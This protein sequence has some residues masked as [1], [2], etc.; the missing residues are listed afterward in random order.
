MSAALVDVREG[1]MTITLNRPETL[2]ALDSA[3]H[4][5]LGTALAEAADPGVRVVV[6]TGAGRGFCSGQDVSELGD[7]STDRLRL[8]SNPN[9]LALRTLEKPVIAAVNGVAA[10]AG[11]ALACAC[12]VRIASERARFV[13]G[14]VALG[15]VP[16]AG[17]TW[18]VTRLLGAAQTFE[19]LGSNRPLEAVEAKQMG[20]VGEV[21]PEAAFSARVAVVAAAYAAAPTRALGLMKLLIDGAAGRTLDDQLEVEASVQGVA[22]ATADFREGVAAFREKRPARFTG[23]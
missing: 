23:R 22:R 21:V 13:P 14:F 11:L 15:L 3:L 17:A 18:T 7:E 19:W 20:L 10:G 6:L 5:A 16:D 8:Y 4:R 12:D 1:V 9:V 2:N